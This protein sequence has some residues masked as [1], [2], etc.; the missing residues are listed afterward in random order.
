MSGIGPTLFVMVV[1]LA[2]FVLG[3]TVRDKQADRD[4]AEARLQR[5]ED[6]L[7]ASTLA[8]TNFSASGREHA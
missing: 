6:Q 7:A 3:W 4:E 5:I 1:A 2:G 8:G